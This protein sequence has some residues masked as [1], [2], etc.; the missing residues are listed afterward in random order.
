MENMEGK[1]KILYVCLL[2]VLLSDSSTG[3]LWRKP[4]RFRIHKR[5]RPIRIFNFPK[6]CYGKPAIQ[7][8]ATTR[9]PKALQPTTKATTEPSV[10]VLFKPVV[11]NDSNHSSGLPY[12]KSIDVNAILN[13]RR[14]KREVNTRLY[15]C[16]VKVIVKTYKNLCFDQILIDR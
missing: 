6:H 15:L 10:R 9:K 1:V 11:S 13:G 16:L 3:L 4:K 14:T 12:C 2:A 8:L 7:M 5:T